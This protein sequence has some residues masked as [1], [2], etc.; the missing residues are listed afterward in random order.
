MAEH[1]IPFTEKYTHGA[2]YREKDR[3]KAADFPKRWL[4]SE[5]DPTLFDFF[6]PK[7]QRDEK[8]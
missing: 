6:V 8:H 1:V 5:G 7:P 4:K 2:V 3:S